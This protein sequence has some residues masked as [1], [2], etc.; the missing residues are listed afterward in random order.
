MLHSHPRA[1]SASA[2]SGPRC[3]YGMQQQ[4]DGA[5][6][7]Q[8]ACDRCGTQSDLTQDMAQ[9]KGKQAVCR[10]SAA[11]QCSNCHLPWSFEAQ[12]RH[13]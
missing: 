2:F 5:V 12:V 7:V 4:S 9:G 11:M 10:P 13:A 8:L 1:V 3:S 6:S